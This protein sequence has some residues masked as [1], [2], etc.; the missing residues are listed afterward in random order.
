V[1]ANPDRSCCADEEVYGKTLGYVE[2]VISKLPGA[3][4]RLGFVSPKCGSYCIVNLERRARQSNELDDDTHANPLA[5]SGQTIYRRSL[6]PVPPYFQALPMQDWV[7]DRTAPYS[8]RQIPPLIESPMQMHTQGHTLNTA[9]TPLLENEPADMSGLALWAA[10]RDCSTPTT[11]IIT[12]STPGLCNYCG[13]APGSLQKGGGLRQFRRCKRCTSRSA[14]R[15]RH[16]GR[17]VSQLLPPAPHPE[18]TMPK[19]LK[20][21]Q[22]FLTRPRLCDYQ[23]CRTP[24]QSSLMCGNCK[25]VAYCSKGCQ[26]SAHHP[27]CWPVSYRASVGQQTHSLSH[28]LHR[29]Q[30]LPH[31]ASACPDKGMEGWAQERVRTGVRAGSSVRDGSCASGAGSA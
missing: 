24:L 1:H 5:A 9:K 4:V 6:S 19:P 25:S 10:N 23:G 20:M 16:R 26:V 15:C 3:S 31:S 27:A 21:S 14:R 18:A 13:A 30:T 28:V 2:T 17:I 8:P 29:A 22:S 7:H 12:D 11:D